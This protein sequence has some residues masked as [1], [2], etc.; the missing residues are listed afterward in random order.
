MQKFQC[1]NYSKKN[2]RFY[3]DF[4]FI[5]NAD[6]GSKIIRI[7][8]YMFVCLLLHCDSSGHNQKCFFFISIL[9]LTYYLTILMAVF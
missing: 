9:A 7:L 5:V 4:K 6:K 3:L 2:S 1:G 8:H